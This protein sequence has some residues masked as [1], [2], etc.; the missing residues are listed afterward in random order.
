M[1]I[2]KRSFALQRWLV[3]IGVFAFGMALLPGLASAHQSPAGCNVDVTSVSVQQNPVGSVVPGQKVKFTV[4]IGNPGPGGG[5]PCDGGNI[6]GGDGA[7]D[8]EDVTFKCPTPDGLVPLVTDPLP[9]TLGLALPL[10]ADG[11]DNKTFPTG[12]ADCT[13]LG[14]SIFGSD[15]CCTGVM[16]GSCPSTVCTITVNAGVTDVFATARMKGQFHVATPD[17][18]TFIQRQPPV[19]VVPCTV[20]IDKQ[21]SCD[22]GANFVDVGLT[23]N[24]Q[25]DGMNPMGITESCAGWNAFDGMDAEDIIVRY[26]VKNNGQSNLFSC[27]IVD[28]NG[29]ITGP[30]PVGNIAPGG[31]VMPSDVINAC[32]E[33]LDDLEPDTATVTCDCTDPAVEE[34][35][36]TAFDKAEFDCQTPGLAIEK[37]CDKLMDGTDEVTLTITNNGTADFENCVVTDSIFLDD[38]TCPADVGSGTDVPIT[39]IMTLNSGDP[40]VIRMANVGDLDAAACNTAQV[41]CDISDAP[42]SSD[43]CVGDGDP[44]PCCTGDATG[45]CEH[46]QITSETD[47]LCPDGEGC[48]TRTP[49]FWKNHPQV[50]DDFLSITTCGLTLTTTKQVTQDMCINDREAKAAN[51]SMQQLQLIRQC[52]AAALKIAASVE[53]GGD[54][55]SF[56]GIDTIFNTCCDAVSVCTSASTGQAIS[57]SGCI[58]QLDAF[59]NS[60]DTLLPFGPFNPPGKAQTAECK[61]SNKD[62]AVNPGRTLGPR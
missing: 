1:K 23:D 14:T 32:S 60:G 48:L 11:S 31:Q 12:N 54:C 36:A 26:K 24:N 59:N 46:K 20:Q 49:G 44:F 55:G 35:K 2:S 5:I 56:F 6:I 41:T 30:I 57:E 8:G 45:T 16:T 7:S 17:G 42:F 10:H 43:D 38:P 15:A 52:A 37:D 47:A 28:S 22:G 58:D 61:A 4:S 34:L 3:A 50:T 29:A 21:I 33:S 19:N 18:L 51:T 13:G 53:G 25:T 27:D 62:G 40:A 39:D 9:V